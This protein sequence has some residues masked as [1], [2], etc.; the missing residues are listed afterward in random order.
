MIES[1]HPK[2]QLR[3]SGAPN[4]RIVKIWTRP[5]PHQVPLYAIVS[6]S[7]P[8]YRGSWR[9]VGTMCIPRYIRLS[10]CY[11]GAVVINTLGEVY[12]V[13]YVRH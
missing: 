13:V 2:I 4:Q 7:N 6:A 8:G 12:K 10:H 3:H 11:C 5:R 1:D 9:V